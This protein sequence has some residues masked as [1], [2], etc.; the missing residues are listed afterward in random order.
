MLELLV[1]KGARAVLRGRGAGDSTSLPDPKEEF[2]MQ[3]VA[4]VVIAIVVLVF[5]LSRLAKSKSGTHH[6]TTSPSPGTGTYQP[7]VPASKRGPSTLSAAEV[8]ARVRELRNWNGQWPEIWTVLNPGDDPTV[9]QLLLDLRND[10][11]QFAPHD[12][13]RRIEL[14]S[15]DLASIGCA[16]V[17]TVLR[18]VLGQTDVLDKFE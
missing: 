18:K 1:S 4:L 13:L 12:G 16:D 9:Q 15:E 10:G 17:V 14:A 7:T 6:G 8:L 2:A 3:W 11:L 5:V